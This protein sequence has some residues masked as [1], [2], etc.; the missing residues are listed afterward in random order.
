LTKSEQS[1]ERSAL[2]RSDPAFWKQSLERSPLQRSDPAV[3]SDCGL[4][5]GVGVVDSWQLGGCLIIATY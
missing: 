5:C 2:Q 1:L 3:A 4:D